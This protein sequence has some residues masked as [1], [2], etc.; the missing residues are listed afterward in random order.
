MIW[1]QRI[2]ATTTQWGVY[3]NGGGVDRWRRSEPL[4]SLEQD[5]A[6]RTWY[7]PYRSHLRITSQTH[8]QTQWY[9]VS[10]QWPKQRLVLHPIS[11]AHLESQALGG[12][13]WE[14]YV[15]FL[16][17]ISLW[18]C[19]SSY[20]A[21]IPLPGPNQHSAE[22]EISKTTDHTMESQALEPHFC[23]AVFPWRSVCVFMCSCVPLMRR[24]L[25]AWTHHHSAEA[26]ISKTTDH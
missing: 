23:L 25:P 26:A 2:V 17:N 24:P 21:S 6:P 10:W 13:I 22:A 15:F 3:N 14:Q 4:G 19:L 8:R 7:T 11:I 5:P 16:G 20:H 18:I 1:R 9:T 12:P